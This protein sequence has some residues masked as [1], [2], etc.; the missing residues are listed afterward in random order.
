M[1][2]LLHIV[3][4]ANGVALPDPPIYDGGLDADTWY[5]LEDVAIS[6]IDLSGHFSGT[7][8]S[9]GATGLPPGFS[10]DPDTCVLS[11]TPTTSGSSSASIFATNTGGS[12]GVSGL[13]IYVINATGGTLNKINVSGQDYA[14]WDFNDGDTWTPNFTH[15]S[16]EYEFQASGASGGHGVVAGGGGAG[17]RKTGTTSITASTGYPVVLGAAGT[18]PSSGQPGVNGGNASMFGITVDGGGGGGSA[19]QLTGSAGGCGGGGSGNDGVN[20]AGGDGTGADDRDGGP[21]HG[22]GTASQR[23]GG[24][25]GGIGANGGAGGVGIGGNGGVG[26]QST[27]NGSSVWLGTGGPGG[28]PSGGTP[29]NS[30]D[31]GS[32]AVASVGT[33]A[34]TA[35]SGGF[36]F[37]GPARASASVSNA[38]TV[39]RMQVRVAL[40]A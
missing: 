14:H 30:S 10:L 37:G 2:G 25:G 13:P 39:G 33:G 16:V 11:G 6:S 17:D 4:A 32:T 3:G 29:G 12:D 26:I 23:A 5:F 21:S 31:G 40:T 35:A 8:D 7:I 9:Y 27:F 1:S 22:S 28:A 19:A 24:A 38:G 36:G 18:S 20:Q 15:G 34:C